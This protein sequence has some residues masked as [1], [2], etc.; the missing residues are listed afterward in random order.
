MPEWT[1]WTPTVSRLWR[2]ARISGALLSLHYG[3][4][5]LRWPSPWGLTC[6]TRIYVSSQVYYANFVLVFFFHSDWT[7]A[8][9]YLHVTWSLRTGATT[10][11]QNSCPTAVQTDEN[12][13]SKIKDQHLSYDQHSS[14]NCSCTFMQETARYQGTAAWSTK[15]GMRPALSSLFFLFSFHLSSV[16]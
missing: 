3:L 5:R 1:G 16:C 9:D 8:V 15:E 2:G 4:T 12:I 7:F 6:I 14:C 11:N 13:R 10:F